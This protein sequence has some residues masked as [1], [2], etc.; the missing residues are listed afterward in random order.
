MTSSPGTN[1]NVTYPIISNVTNARVPEDGI[2][3]TALIQTSIDRAGTN[4]NDP[5][6]STSDKFIVSEYVQV[7][8]VTSRVGTGSHST[9]SIMEST[10]VDPK[11]GTVRLYDDSNPR[12]AV[13]DT[14]ATRDI[15]LTKH[16]GESG[17]HYRGM[18]TDSITSGEQQVLEGVTRQE[19]QLGSTLHVRCYASGIRE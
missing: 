11:G 13:E 18:A 5:T 12:V 4:R 2:T 7:S 15:K 10:N 9:D 14:S 1:L 6:A 8:T 16:K 19:P 3:S 17:S